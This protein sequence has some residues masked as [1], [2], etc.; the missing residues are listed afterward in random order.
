MNTQWQEVIRDLDGPRGLEDCVGL[1]SM[2][3][4]TEFILQLAV[5]LIA[6]SVG[7]ILANRLGYPSL[8]GELIVGILIGPY[9]L[10]FVEYSD[11]LLIFAE[12]GAIILLFYIG[13]ETEFEKLAEHFAPS[14]PY[15]EDY[16]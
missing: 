6:V 12:L 3:A 7:G 5:L 4:Y 2:I 15:I 8:L 16:T 10:G 1:V 9:A 14:L 13:L 11:V